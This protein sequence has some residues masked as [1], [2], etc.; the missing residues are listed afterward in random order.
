MDAGG[1]MNTVVA[2]QD[3]RAPGAPVG[4]NARAL[5]GHNLH[6]SRAIGFGAPTTSLVKVTPRSWAVIMADA[7]GRW[8]GVTVKVG[9]DTCMGIVNTYSPCRERE[10]GITWR[11]S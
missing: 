3:V 2:I 6:I 5:R 4:V 9:E 1:T 11:C 8:L 10:R 7:G